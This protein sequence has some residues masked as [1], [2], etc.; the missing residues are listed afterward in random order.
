MIIFLLLFLIG[1]A[2]LIWVAW[3]EP[4]R[5]IRKEFTVPLRHLKSPLKAVVIGDLQPNTF[6][7]DGPRLATLFKQIAEEETPDVVLWLGDYYNAH[8]DKTKTILDASP[9]L[10]AWVDQFLPKMDDIAAA[11][12]EL[13][14][15]LGAVAVLGNHDWAW[16]G[17]QT[18]AALTAVGIRVLNDDIAVLGDGDAVLQVIGYEDHA[19]GRMPNFAAV[20]GRRD[21]GLP[22][23]ALSHSPDAFPLDT[24]GPE[25]M[26][27][28]HSHGGQVR[29]PW[30][31]PILLPL[32][33]PEYDRGW[34]SMQ[35][36][37][38]FVT[39]GLGTSLPP[40]RLLC[41]PEY[42]VLNLVPDGQD[43]G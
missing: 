10:K 5:V 43:G 23:L 21:E 29:L 40:L 11:M 18:E 13:P 25:L 24:D 1:V 28:G 35:N 20:L 33:N 3:I 32:E 14:G 42:V 34:F 16:S 39:S 30:V 19:S 22:T 37:R 31:G 4:R 41:P 2:V 38:L 17:R 26:L 8:T 6:H 36:R 15:R 9:R 7:W 12:A 27:S